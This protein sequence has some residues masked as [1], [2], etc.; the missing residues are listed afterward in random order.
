MGK[1]RYS[2]NFETDERLTEAEENELIRYITQFGNEVSLTDDGITDNG[3]TDDGIF[4][5]GEK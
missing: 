2:I 3:I 5:R 1:I 4:E